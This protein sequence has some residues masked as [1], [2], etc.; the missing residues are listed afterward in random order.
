MATTKEAVCRCDQLDDDLI[1]DG[2]TCYHCYE[3][4]ADNPDSCNCGKGEN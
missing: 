1:E 3:I 2:W 4:H